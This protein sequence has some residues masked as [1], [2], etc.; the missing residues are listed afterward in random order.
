[1]YV[2][3]GACSGYWVAAHAGCCW[4]YSASCCWVAANAARRAAVSAVIVDMVSWMDWALALFA[5][6]MLV[7]LWV[8][9]PTL[10][11]SSAVS[12]AF[13]APWY[14]FAVLPPDWSRISYAS[15]KCDLNLDQIWL[16]LSKP[17][18]S[19]T[20]T[21]YRPVVCTAMSALS[22]IC[23]WVYAGLA[24]SART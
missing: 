22:I 24:L 5:R 3:S 18:H 16:T 4:L 17:F 10:S 21:G 2:G 13:A 1:M 19:R 12:Y 8:I 9:D 11:S 15:E 23:S 7:R 20:T 6:C 14:M